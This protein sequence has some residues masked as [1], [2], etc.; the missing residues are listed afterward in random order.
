MTVLPSVLFLDYPLS[1]LPFS[2][3]ATHNT[4]FNCLVQKKKKSQTSV[5]QRENHSALFH[6][7]LMQ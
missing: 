7:Y 2:F 1:T 3:P 4:H 5:Q 6:T